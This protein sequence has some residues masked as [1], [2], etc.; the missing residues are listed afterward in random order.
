MTSLKRNRLTLALLL[1]TISCA[2]GI[3]QTQPGR[4]GSALPYLN[5]DIPLE[6][7][8][9][10]LVSRMT[11]DEKVRQMLYNAPAIE[12]LRVPSYNWWSEA[13]HGVARAGKATVFPQAIGLAATWDDKLMLRVASVISDEARAKYHDALRH[14]R[15]GIYEGLTFWSPNINIFRDP[16]WG[17]G[18]ETYGEDPYLAGRLGVEFVKG[19]QG[20]N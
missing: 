10:D 5:P 14:N 9:T 1:V 7:R 6:Q 8:V 17:R 3:A 4:A 19:M 11:L 2:S 15:R 13:L 20:D 12:R 16:R 18:M